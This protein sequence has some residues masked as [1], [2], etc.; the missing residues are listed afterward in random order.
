MSAGRLPNLI[1][2]DGDQDPQL[3]EATV[4]ETPSSHDQQIRVVIPTFSFQD[5]IG[6][7]PWTPRVEPHPEP[8]NPSAVI[9]RFPTRGDRAAVAFTADGDPWIV[10]WWPY[11]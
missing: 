1:A 2:N 10:A 3:H 9:F 6:P 5:R 8:D 4:A 7:C 11:Q